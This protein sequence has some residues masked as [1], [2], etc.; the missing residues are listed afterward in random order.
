MFDALA[1]PH[2]F[3][4]RTRHPARIA[5]RPPVP[6]HLQRGV[7]SAVAPAIRWKDWNTKPTSRRRKRAPSEAVQAAHLALA[8]PHAAAIGGEQAGGRG[9]AWS[10]PSRW[11]HTAPRVAGRNRQRD[12]VHR[13]HNLGVAGV[14][15]DEPAQLQAGARDDPERSNPPGWRGE[16]RGGNGTTFPGS[17]PTRTRSPPPSDI[18][19]SVPCPA[20]VSS[21]A[22]ISAALYSRA[23]AR[24]SSYSALRSSRL[25]AAE[26]SSTSSRCGRRTSARASVAP[27]RSP[28]ASGAAGSSAQ[29][30]APTRTT[31]CVP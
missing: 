23:P 17:S 1:Q 7:A 21:E 27:M 5:Q 29:S 15:L 30:L 26:G 20:S 25:G 14:V 13:P 6:Q 8:E 10:C 12:P 3:E 31:S 19:P 18:G 28:T 2:T 4:P 16:W 9:A 11:A 24:S 22:P